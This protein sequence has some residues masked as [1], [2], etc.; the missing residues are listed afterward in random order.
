MRKWWIKSI[1][2]ATAFFT[3]PGIACD[4]SDLSIEFLQGMGYANGSG[5]A[6]VTGKFLITADSIEEGDHCRIK[7][8]EVEINLR[9]P[10]TDQYVSTVRTTTSFRV[11]LTE[12]GERTEVRLHVVADFDGEPSTPI[13]NGSKLEVVNVNVLPIIDE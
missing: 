4:S 13:R 7:A 11:F 8:A 10:A 1:C 6:L 12:E 5:G 2:G 3:V 9:D